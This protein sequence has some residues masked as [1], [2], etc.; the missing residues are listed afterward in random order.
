VQ[1]A[2]GA[3]VEPLALRAEAGACLEVTLH[4][5]LI[6]QAMDNDNNLLFSCEEILAGSGECDMATLEPLFDTEEAQDA[7]D[8]G[9][10]LAQADG[11]PVPGVMP[12][13]IL[14]NI[15]FDQVPD[16]AG[17]QDVFWVVNRDLFNLG[18]R[19]AEMHF[20]NNNLIRPSD[21]VG[22]HASDHV[23]LHA[24]LVEYDASRDDGLIVGGN[25]QMPLARP[26]GQKTYRYYAGDLRSEPV[27]GDFELVATPVEFGASNL[28]SA[29]R[30][31]QPQKGL[32]GALVI[33]PAGAT[34]DETTLVADGQANEAVTPLATRL[35]RA[36]V[37]VTSTAG[38]AGSGG[39]YRE[40]L[41]IGHKITNL[42]WKDGTAI[43][44]VNQGEL[45]REGA[46][47]SGHAGFNYGMEPSWFR[48]KLAP[49]APF[50]NAGTPNSY[51]S[52]PNVHAFYAN[53]LAAGEPNSVPLID[54]GGEPGARYTDV[55]TERRLRGP[56]RHLHPA[57]PRV[58]ARSVRLHRLYH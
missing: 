41:A 18:Q 31:K 26:G 16:L 49:D 25:T 6:D 14:N 17:W 36:Q 51:G 39:T 15:V 5:K 56:R 2:V 9:L 7:L 20:F 48:F 50:G 24:Q 46:E 38:E 35:T 27:G 55:R 1:L 3:P 22:L 11:T 29:D 10:L 34:V 21:H 42:R 37:T 57:R 8:Q 12:E 54:G 28:L 13:D 23:G 45:G 44:N 47:D 19:P 33:E 53:G 32:F 58:A 30:V 4:N 43:A 52:I 40:A